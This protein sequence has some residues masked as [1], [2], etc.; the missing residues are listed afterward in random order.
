MNVHSILPFQDLENDDFFTNIH[1]LQ[2]NNLIHVVDANINYLDKLLFN[3]FNSNINNHTYVNDPDSNFFNN[4][5]EK[6]NSCR[7]YLC[8]VPG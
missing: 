8:S 1:E 3:Q 4:F 5:L 7:Y 6:V 2:T